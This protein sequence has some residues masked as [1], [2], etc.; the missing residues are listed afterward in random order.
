MMSDTP[1][2][3]DH[4]S[5]ADS[6][7]AAVV[8]AGEAPT[9][10]IVQVPQPRRLRDWVVRAIFILLMMSV[11]INVMLYTTTVELTRTTPDRFVSGDEDAS[12]QI[13]VIDIHGTIIP[14]FTE[15]ILGMIERASDDDSVKGVLLSID[16]PGGLVADS[17]QIYHRLQQLSK[18]KPIWVSMK[19]IAASG[20]VYVAMGI[21][22]KGRIFVE[23][24][25]WTGSI[26]VIIPRYDMSEL[27]KTY[28]V[29]SDS[30]TTGEFKDS[31]NPF[32]PLSDRDR[33]LWGEILEDA[34]DRFV[35]VV[36]DGREALDKT[37]VRNELAT[38]QIF[39]ANQ[40]VKNKL[41]DEIQFEDDVL[42]KFQKHL[43]LDECK[44]IRYRH[45]ASVLEMLLS[46]AQ[47]PDP[48]T[49][50]AQRVLEATVP[51]AMY[52]FSWLPALP[53]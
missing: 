43:K 28:G 7:P 41:V 4:E 25:T 50:L 29:A 42:V 30:L 35:T 2:T 9:Q 49:A 18:K 17:H 3:T 31:M 1:E 12:D 10:V 27:A 20:G 15:R 47:A 19:R 6:K 11:M 52:Y 8:P 46:K 13:V 22:P 44:I 48:Q 45:P 23:P 36:A 38:G 16:S 21:G 32:K 39:T 51:R 24:T 37:T 5:T 33:A 26:G 34:Y 53:K 14:P 40:A